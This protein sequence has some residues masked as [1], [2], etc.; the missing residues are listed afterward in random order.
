M[1]YKFLIKKMINYEYLVFILLFQIPQS[2]ETFAE[3]FIGY[4]F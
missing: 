3:L 2:R 4:L 1:T